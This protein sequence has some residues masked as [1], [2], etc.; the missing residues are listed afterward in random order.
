MATCIVV[1]DRETADGFRL[2]GV[3]VRTAADRGEAAAVLEAILAAGECGLV[4]VKE[5]FCEGLDGR[6]VRRIEREGRP[7]LVPLPLDMKWWREEKGMDYVLRLIR[8]SIG[9]QMRIRK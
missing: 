1:T 3:E 5:A 7:L 4:L 6:I 8:R 2:A 9:Y